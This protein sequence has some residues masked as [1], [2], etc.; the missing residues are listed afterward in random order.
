VGALDRPIETDVVGLLWT[1]DSFAADG[2]G[3]SLRML[4]FAS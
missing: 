1:D 3:T 2:L 4:N